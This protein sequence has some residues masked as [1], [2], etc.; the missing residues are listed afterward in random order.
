MLKK[1]EKKTIYCTGVNMGLQGQGQGKCLFHEKV[2]RISYW[3]SCINPV[4]KYHYIVI[5][6]LS[7]ISLGTSGIA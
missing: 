7:F 2:R 4:Y 1:S 6:V 5:T 3:R